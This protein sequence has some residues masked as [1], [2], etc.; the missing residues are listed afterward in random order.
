MYLLF[1]WGGTKWFWGGTIHNE[2]HF[3]GGGGPSQKDL[4]RVVYPLNNKS[5]VEIH[6]Q[7]SSCHNHH[8]NETSKH[9][10]RPRFLHVA[11][12]QLFFCLSFCVRPS[13]R[14]P[15]A[16]V[17]LSIFSSVRPYNRLSLSLLVSQSVRPPV[18]LSVSLLVSQSVRPPV[19]LSVSLLVSQSVRPPVYL[20]V[21]MTVF[22]SVLLPVCLS[23]CLYVL[24]F[25]CL[26]PVCLSVFLFVSLSVRNS[27]I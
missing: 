23:V 8:S 18:Y 11:F 22:Q 27:F 3:K 10:Q 12:L 2:G 13:V 16:F 20:S 17:R 5:L 19:Y 4:G 26:S 21:C 24:L 6:R 25:V 15:L 1:I 9:S 7:L 14:R